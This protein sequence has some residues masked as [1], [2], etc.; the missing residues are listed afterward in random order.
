MPRAKVNGVELEYAEFGEGFPLVWS[1]EFAG[2]MESWLPQVHYFARRY[3]VITY[4]ARGYPPSEVPNDPAAY[5]Q[6]I[7]VED[8]FGLLKHVGVDEAYIGGLSMG[9]ATALHFG[10]RHPE[11]A[12]ALIIAA[13]GSGSTNPEQ[14]RQGCMNL[15]DRL[16]K[17]GAAAFADYAGGPS[18]LQLRRK[19]PAGYQEFTD[20]LFAHSPSGSAHTMRGVQAGRPPIFAWEKE[21][22]ALAAPVLVL[23]GDEDGACIE[24]ALFMKRHIPSCGLAVLPQS[25]HGINLE[26]PALFNALVSD[27]LAAVEAGKW[28][29]R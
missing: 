1:H 6:D 24:P 26:E 15:A 4:N 7:A 2:S 29:R 9:G 28:D 12:R 19:D 11:M 10:I 17:E 21:M 8:L 23:V 22:Q 27:F 18:R 16:E 14:F 25:G 5:S 20:L 3:R 13:A